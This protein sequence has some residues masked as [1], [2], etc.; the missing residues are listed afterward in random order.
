MLKVLL[1]GFLALFWPLW[2]PPTPPSGSVRE[3]QLLSLPLFPSPLIRK[4]IS[5]SKA[6]AEIGVRVQGGYMLF[7][8]E[9]DLIDGREPTVNLNVASENTLGEALRQIFSQVPRYRYEVVSEHLINV[10]PV[11]AKDDPNDVLNAKIEHLD[12]D[13]EPDWLIEEPQRFMP[14]VGPLL[15]RR[16]NGP[17]A[18]PGFPSVVATGGEPKVSLRLDGVTVRQI[19]NAL[20]EATE[21]YPARWFPFS[22]VVTFRPDDSFVAGGEYSWALT[23]SVPKTWKQEPK[24]EKSN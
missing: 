8:A 11:G 17:P 20:S 12:F 22:W 21:T 14:E 19:L 3:S 15:A 6:L 1:I 10:Y 16:T 2:P 9:I 23:P 5:L 24:G 13:E 18:P 4:Q 7:G